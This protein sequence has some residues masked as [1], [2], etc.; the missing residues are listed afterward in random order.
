MLPCS[1]SQ[2]EIGRATTFVWILVGAA[3]ISGLLFGM[4][5]FPLSLLF[6]T[7]IVSLLTEVGYD[8]GVISGTLVVIGTDLGTILTDWDKVSFAKLVPV[9]ADIT[10]EVI[11]SAT[12]LGALIG[13]LAA[14]VISDYGRKP[15]IILANIV[16]ISGALLQA[17]SLGSAHS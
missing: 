9:E 4:R 2:A 15:A 6:Y 10:Q 7:P 14:G 1:L 11:T 12:T 3:A 13:G 5:L 17:V 8:T 16:F